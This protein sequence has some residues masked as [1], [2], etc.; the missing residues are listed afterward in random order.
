MTAPPVRLR[1]PRRGLPAPSDLAC[2]PAGTA[3]PVMV[4]NGTADR[5]NPYDGGTVRLPDG[6]SLGNV[7]SAAET[8]RYFGRLWPAA[9]PAEERSWRPARPGWPCTGS[10][11]ATPV[12]TASSCTP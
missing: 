6:S 11:G 10:G 12:V 8:A 3:V 9:R 2:V 4:V 5:I 1:S 7:V